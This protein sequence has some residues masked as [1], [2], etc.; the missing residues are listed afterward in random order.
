MFIL[1]SV[2]IKDFC[3][4]NADFT[5][6]TLGVRRQTSKSWQWRFEQEMRSFVIGYN[7]FQR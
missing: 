4:F 3:L 7:L 6:A 2:L 1:Q 5:M